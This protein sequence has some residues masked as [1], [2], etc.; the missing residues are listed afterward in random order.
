MKNMVKANTMKTKVIAALLAATA[1]CTVTTIGVTAFA[2]DKHPGECGYN[3]VN[4]NGKHPGEA[5]YNYKA[6]DEEVNENGKHPGE[7]GY[8]YVNENGKHPGE[9]GYNYKE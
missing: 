8:N 9:A 3:Y 2:A 7:C 4:E 1:I 6:D 5:G